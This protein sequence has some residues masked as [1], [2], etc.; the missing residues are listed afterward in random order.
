MCTIIHTTTTGTEDR[1]PSGLMLSLQLKTMGILETIPC[2][3]NALCITQERK[4]IMQISA[5]R[6]PTHCPGKSLMLRDR[7][8]PKTRTCKGI[9]IVQFLGHLIDSQG[10]HVDPAKIKAVKNW[11]SSTTPTEIR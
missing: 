2:V 9:R 1:K 4:G 6:T 7:D 11:T 3:R 10:L 5:E 8:A